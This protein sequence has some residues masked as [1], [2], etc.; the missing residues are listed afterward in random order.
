MLG[1]PPDFQILLYV[2]INCMEQGALLLQNSL[3]YHCIV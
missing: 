2:Y 1:I 3:P